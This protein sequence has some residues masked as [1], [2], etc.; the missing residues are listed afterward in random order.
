[1][2]P[3][4]VAFLLFS[5]DLSNEVKRFVDVLTTVQSQAADPV[6]PAKAIYEGAIPGML[7]R[8]D[9]HSV[10]FRSGAI[11]TT[12]AH[13][14]I[15][16]QG[17][18]QRGLRPAGTRDCVGRR[19]P[20][21]P[22]AKSGIAPGDE[23]LAVNNIRLDLLDIDQLV[24]VLSQTR[25]GQAKLDVR[26]RGQRALVAVRDDAR[27][28]AGAQRRPRILAAPRTLAT[29]VWR[30]SMK[31]PARRFGMRSRNWAAQTCA[32]SCSICA[33]IPAAF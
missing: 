26:R 6:Q 12:S 18:R 17:V 25:Q 23:I 14:E 1:M 13:G 33:T 21:T 31:R 20:G 10:L 22:S 29:C 30:A 3:L 9:P 8:L 28:D 15:D 16:K 11:R 19:L 24:E 7:R 27:G 32:A 2:F 4:L 5:D